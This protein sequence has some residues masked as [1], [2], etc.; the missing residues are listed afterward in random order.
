MTPQETIQD[1]LENLAGTGKDCKP[2]ITIDQA[3]SQ[4]QSYYEAKVLSVEEMALEIYCLDY[5]PNDR[6]LVIEKWGRE[7]K[8][9]KSKFYK[10]AQAL[11]SKQMSKMKGE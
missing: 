8:R 2:R 5:H 4:I 7:T 9:E 1:I 10:R 6:K 3:L 11:H